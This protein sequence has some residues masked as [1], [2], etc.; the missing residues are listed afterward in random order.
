MEIN[1][2][3]VQDLLTG[4]SERTIAFPPV[5]ARITGKM[6]AGVAL[7]QLVYWWSSKGGQWLYKTDVEVCAE[8]ALTPD[9]WVAAKKLLKASGFVSIEL[10]GLPA[11]S[12]YFVHI[13]KITD[14][15]VELQVSGNSRNKFADGKSSVQDSGNY[16][17]QFR[18]F[19]ETCYRDS[20]KH[21]YIVEITNKNTTEI[22]DTAPDFV[23]VTDEPEHGYACK[24]HD[25][26]ANREKL[27]TLGFNTNAFDTMIA[28]AEQPEIAGPDAPKRK[29]KQSEK[30]LTPEDQFGGFDNFLVWIGEMYPYLDASKVYNAMQAWAENGGAAK[31][32]K[33]GGYNWKRVPAS[34]MDRD[35]K[36]AEQW[37]K[38]APQA[39]INFEVV[40]QVDIHK[41][42]QAQIQKA[43]Q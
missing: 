27:Q 21:T 40:Q 16:G 34:W 19:P 30:F 17:T 29:K 1:R 26:S 35:S 31:V 7:A 13:D 43:K 25:K 39:Q 32:K 18:E 36:Q 14:A 42:V 8:T 11:K 10:R 33:A 20:P 41:L 9:E 37:R 2:K 6:T 5:Y 38:S 3:Y 24:A 15:I 4:L 22:T 23:G 12:H 28:A